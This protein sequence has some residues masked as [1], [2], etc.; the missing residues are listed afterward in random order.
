LVTDTSRLA[1]HVR[2]GLSAPQKRLSSLYFYDDEGSRIFAEI[3]VL[4]EYYLTRCEREILQHR[5]AEIARWISEGARAIDLVE[6]GSGDGSKTIELLTTLAQAHA[7][8]VYRPLDVSGAALDALVRGFKASLPNLRIEAL[9][10]DY[11][12]LWPDVRR[13]ARQVAMFLGSNLG[14][15]GHD[16]SVS[17]LRRIRSRLR[18]GDCLLLGLD[19]KKHPRLVLAAY[20]DAAGVTARFNLNLLLRLNR[21]LGMDFDVAE[22]EHYATYCPLEG[23]ARSFLVSRRAQRVTS[24]VLG[25]VFS[26]AEGET[27]YVEQSKKYD[28][29]EIDALAAASGFT[30]EV[31][32]CDR[33]GFYEVVA[34]RALA[35][36]NTA[37]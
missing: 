4:P 31:S 15:L 30:P 16:V 21:E 10:G 12:E 23:A 6:L 9:C 37:Q 35:E 2:Q 18:S 3:M 8:L 19:L 17:L 22:F 36:S 5:G 1:E 28:T 11:F 27:I 25:Q 13:D 24:S 14:N 26:F 34:W 32:F 20:D 7:S 29:A 33:R